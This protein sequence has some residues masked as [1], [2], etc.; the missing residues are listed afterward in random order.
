MHACIHVKECMHAH[1]YA[2]CALCGA[3]WAGV[4]RLVSVWPL[5][6]VENGAVGVS[7]N[8]DQEGP[9]GAFTHL[10]SISH[11]AQLDL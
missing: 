5:L 1:M 3:V 7:G 4:T 8:T 10:H 6:T 9:S 2:E 11:F